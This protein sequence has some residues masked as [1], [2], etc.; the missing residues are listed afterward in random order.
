MFFKEFHI[1]IFEKYDIKKI[2]EAINKFQNHE[3]AKI[4]L[5]EFIDKDKNK[6]IEI[7]EFEEIF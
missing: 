5:V 2:Y 7:N 3:I 4:N 1:E 6:Y